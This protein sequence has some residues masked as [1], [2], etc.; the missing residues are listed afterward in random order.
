VIVVT[1]AAGF[2]GSAIVWALNKKGAKDIIIVD[3]NDLPDEKKKNLEALTFKDYIEKNEFLKKIQEDS[4]GDSIQAIVHL[5]ACSDTTQTDEAYLMSNNY[6]YTKTLCEYSMKRNIR[7]VYASSAATYGGGSG[8]YSDSEQ[9]IDSLKPLNLYGESKQVFDKWAQDNN[10]LGKIVGLKYFNVFGPNEYHK[11]DMRSV[12]LKGF[13]QIKDTDKIQ[14]FKSYKDE[15]KD[16]EQKRDFLYVKDAV[17]MTLFFLDNPG[18]NGIFNI[19]SGVARTWNELANA[20]FL[21]LDKQPSIEYI[22]MPENLKAKYQY[23]T[24]ADIT[25]LRS[26]GYNEPIT[27]LKDAAKDYVQNY[28]LPHSR[29]S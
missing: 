16:G 29:L 13:D 9:L 2:I 14:L 23:F 10:L 21:A 17:K 25:K 22:D 11:K 5:G 18:T 26:A 7:F 12:V 27:S 4:F 24:Q 28:L 3:E 20:I 1:G 19:G 8:G 6:E 15:Y